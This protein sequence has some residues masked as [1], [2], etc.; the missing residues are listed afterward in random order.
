MDRAPDVPPPLS[1]RLAAAFSRELHLL[2]DDTRAALLV[3]VVA[4]GDVRL[5][6]SALAQL[7]LDAAGLALAE[8]HG[9]ISI[10]GGQLSF[11]HPLLRA[12]A[13]ADPDE[14][15]RRRAHEVIA[16]LLPNE[17]VDRRTWHLSE[18][19]NGP[20]EDIA[21]MLGSAAE[22]A[23]GRMAYSV[24]STAYERAARLSNEAACSRSRLHEAAA[25]AWQGGLRER[26]L[27][28]LDEIESSAPSGPTDRTLRVRASI[29]I[30]SG[31]VIEAR[32]MLERASAQAESPDDAVVLLAEAVQASVYLADSAGILRLGE[33][34]RSAVGKATTLRATAVGLTAEG[35]VRV[36]SGEGGGEE[37]SQAVAMLAGRADPLRHPEDLSWLMVATLYQRDSS[38]ADPRGIVDDVRASVG[39]GVLPNLL[40]L[41]ARDQATASA[42]TR[43]EANYEE[44]AR[45]AREAGQSTELAMSLAGLSWLESRQGK[46]GACRSHADEA[47]SLCVDRGIP[48]GE[49]WCLFALGD[50]ELAQGN[51]GAA[52]D[53]LLRLDHR[54]QELGF[55]DPDVFPGPELVDALVRLGRD[56]QARDV[57]T[58]FAAAAEDKGRPWSVARAQRAGGLIAPDDCLDGLFGAAL[59]NHR[60]TRD[61]FET[62][63]TQLAYGARLRRAARRV[64]A[65]VQL[66]AALVTF[67]E[68][69]AARWSDVAAAELEATGEKVWRREPTG[70]GA[71]TPQELQ[72]SLQLIDGRTT[73]EAAA[74]LFIS[75]KTV[76]YHLR[77]VYTKLGIH[78]RADLA[79]ALPL[80]R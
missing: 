49:L 31:S 74:A 57:A 33:A 65:R 48:F 44:S 60:G 72:V 68:L 76:E 17:D 34:L 8:R 79:E 40:F 20:D 75:P 32:Q 22:H 24:A 15:W 11:R 80:P 77:K 61:G 1:A 19:V 6:K 39:V 7:G 53:R 46:S 10:A 9:L 62:A 28:L 50:L 63:R 4:N 54:L 41:V 70:V 78:S 16:G 42:W 55:A 58:R 18:S 52:A 23:I 43:A 59:E 35:M 12:A 5:T 13:Y 47:V 29:A 14:R 36:F 67:E 37:F 71:L 66:R 26:A 21:V 25:T 38:G 69:G 56:D 2:D 64:D 73:R 30:R 27:A 45:M 51:A 3:A